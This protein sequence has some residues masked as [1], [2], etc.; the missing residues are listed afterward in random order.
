MVDRTT[1]ED[2]QRIIDAIR[3]NI[4]NF[5]EKPS[6]AFNG[7]PV[8]PFAKKARLENL[9]DIRVLDFSLDELDD[10]ILR[11]IESY[12]ED[13]R[14][15]I[16]FVNPDPNICINKLN[17][18]GAEYESKFPLLTVFRSHPLDEFK[19]AGVNTRR[20]PYANLQFV[21]KRHL[22]EA[23]KTLSKKYYAKMTEENL[24]DIGLI[25]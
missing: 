13:Y 1:M 4:I 23:R 22:E 17:L 6:P 10:R 7:M 12:F 8:C 20:E 3:D 11:V 21:T 14:R 5:I 25:P 2:H 15:L 9:I 19:V 18:I 24:R 16:I